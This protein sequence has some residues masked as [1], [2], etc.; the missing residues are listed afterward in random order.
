MVVLVIVVA[1][2]VIWFVVAAARTGSHVQAVELAMAR[3]LTP[4][5]VHMLTPGDP[6]FAD[7]AWHTRIRREIHNRSNGSQ[8][9][10]E[11]DAAIDAA[12]EEE[13]RARFKLSHPEVQ[14][15]VQPV[16]PKAVEPS[17]IQDFVEAIAELNRTQ[18]IAAIEA[19]MDAKDIDEIDQVVRHGLD[20]D[21][22]MRAFKAHAGFLASNHLAASLPESLEAMIKAGETMVAVFEKLAKERGEHAPTPATQNARSAILAAR[23]A[24]LGALEAAIRSML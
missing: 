3:A 1:A 22:V 12:I 9:P 20:P 14:P 6:L 16:P 24:G 15:T 8:S 5:L 17:A 4:D 19:R 21:K 10:M 23:A 2:A 11:L 13:R 18:R 7:P